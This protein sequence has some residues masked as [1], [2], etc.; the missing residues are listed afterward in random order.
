MPASGRKNEAASTEEG[1]DGEQPS[2]YKRYSLTLPHSYSERIAEIKKRTDA[3][4]DSEAVRRAIRFYENFLTG[5][6][7][8]TAVKH[9]DPAVT[10]ELLGVG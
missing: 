7:A 8:A 4:T 3:S 2:E 9:V 10:E 6:I 5:A 1:R